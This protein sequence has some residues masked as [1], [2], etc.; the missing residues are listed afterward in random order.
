MVKLT[1]ARDWRL[2]GG[3]RKRSEQPAEAALRELAEEIGMTGHGA[4]EE[5]T[6]EAEWA[7]AGEAR[8]H[9]FIVRDVRYRPKPGWEVAAVAEFDPEA[10]P[11]DVSPRW[12]AAIARLAAKP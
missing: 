12:R 1:Y 3:G 4:V 8:G 11:P 5:V 2:P 10:L 6:G 7:R 9:V